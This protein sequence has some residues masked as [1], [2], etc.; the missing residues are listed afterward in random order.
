[1][2]KIIKILGFIASWKYLTNQNVSWWNNILHGWIFSFWFI[3]RWWQLCFINIK[4]KSKTHLTNP[5]D[6]KKKKIKMEEIIIFLD[7]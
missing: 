6:E 5:N 3:A 2:D 4:I 1:M 7:L